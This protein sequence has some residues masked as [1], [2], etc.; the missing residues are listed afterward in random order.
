MFT[1]GG[2]GGH[3]IPALTLIEKLEKSVDILYIGSTSGIEKTLVEG[4]GIRYFSI[5]SGKLRRYFS[6]KNMTDIGCILA[7]LIKSFFI[8]RRLDPHSVVF[9]TGGYVA[10]PVVFSSWIL[11]RKVLIHEQ[12]GQAGLSNRLAS[13]FAT[14]IY[15]SFKDSMKFFPK[16]KTRFSGYPLKD[17]CFRQTIKIQDVCGIDLSTMKRPS[18]F[19]TGGGNGSELI[20]EK[21]KNELGKLRDYTIFHQVG[22]LFIE[23][24]KRLETPTYKVFPFLNEGIIDLFKA[25]DI[26][27]SRAGAG[28][29]CELLALGK[30]SILVPLKIAQKNEQFYNAL[31]AKSYLSS[32]IIEE[33]EFQG[34]S[35]PSLFSSFH[36]D[37]VK[38]PKENPYQ[39]IRGTDFLVAEIMSHSKN[40]DK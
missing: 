36:D 24:Y 1:G 2:S 14:K 9:S 31:E 11:G 33:E 5:P 23:D 4:R 34:I 18:I 17:E 21:V 39:K 12:T 35:L 22:K 30:R 6:L 10:F 32:R 7:G 28:T 16:K 8:L 19:I 20:N 15:V 3:V 26:V 40:S 27:L 29:V 25:V 13:R 38:P 37:K